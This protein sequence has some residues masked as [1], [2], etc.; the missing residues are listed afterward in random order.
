MGLTSTLGAYFVERRVTN[1]LVN[2][3]F[4]YNRM[5]TLF[6]LTLL[7]CSMTIVTVVLLLPFYYEQLRGFGTSR[8]GLLMTPAALVLG[9]VGPVAGR[10]SDRFGSTYLVPLGL[11]LN[12]LS[13]FML[14][15]VDSSTAVAYIVLIL[16]IDGVGL[17]IFFPA[18][19]STLMNNPPAE[20]MGVGS[21]MLSTGR[22]IGQSVGIALAGAIF[23]GLQG[24]TAKNSLEHGQRTAALESTFSHAFATVMLVAGAIGLAAT[25]VSLLR[26]RS[27][28]SPEGPAP[29][30]VPPAHGGPGL[31]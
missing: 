31:P 20:R 21:S 13:F 5:F 24:A 2:L 30:L 4:F 25:I 3:S 17:G 7:L 27:S 18:N 10:L 16:V 12:A 28:A 29:A 22:L 1:P 6:F 26:G 23:N 19:S 8:S 9:V 14:Y 11:L 15:F